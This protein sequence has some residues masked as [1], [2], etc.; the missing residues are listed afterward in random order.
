M[1]KKSSLERH[2]DVI[3]IHFLC[4][5]SVPYSEVSL[6]SILRNS[7]MLLPFFA[8]SLTS[9]CDLAGCAIS[10]QMYTIVSANEESKE[11]SLITNEFM[12]HNIIGF[13]GKGT[14]THSLIHNMDSSDITYMYMCKIH[15]WCVI[16]IRGVIK[17]ALISLVTTGAKFNYQTKQLS[18]TWQRKQKI[19]SLAMYT[20]MWDA[21]L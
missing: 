13:Q 4:P 18:M 3:L 21:I 10:A 6:H 15:H 17:L 2:S 14:H 20:K 5:Q 9:A 1:I 11:C 19:K 16:M 7:L 12:L 8:V